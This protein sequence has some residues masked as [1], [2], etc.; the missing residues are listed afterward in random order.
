MKS[1][2]ALFNVAGVSEVREYRVQ[3]FLDNTAQG[4]ISAVKSIATTP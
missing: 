2:T 3:G 4:A 1:S